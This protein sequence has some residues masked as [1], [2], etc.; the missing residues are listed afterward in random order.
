MTFAL[1]MQQI[2]FLSLTVIFSFATIRAQSK[3]EWSFKE[4]VEQA[5]KNNVS[6][7]Q[8]DL[9]NQQNLINVKQAKANLVP[10]LNISDGQG[11]NFGRTVDPFTNQFVNQNI[12]TNNI[13]ATSSVTLF[14]GMQKTTLSWMY[15]TEPPA[16]SR[17]QECSAE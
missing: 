10:T 3:K 9:N 1:I 2:A 14:G 13:A 15:I 17:P 6:L 7:N 8:A 4:C 5:L 12:N 11:L 16:A